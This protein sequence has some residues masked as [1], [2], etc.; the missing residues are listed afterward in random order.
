MLDLAVAC[1]RVA[2]EVLRKNLEKPRT[3]EKKESQNTNLVT[4]ADREAEER[5]VALISKTYPTHEI[6][7]EESGHR[8]TSSDYRWI[9]DPLDGTTNYAHR[10]P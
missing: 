8:G 7:A 1:A 3:I 2:G 4:D 6:L 10:L 9:I 5:I